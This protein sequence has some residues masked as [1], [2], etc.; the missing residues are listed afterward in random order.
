M[1]FSETNVSYVCQYARSLLPYQPCRFF[2]LLRGFVN[3][4]DRISGLVEPDGVFVLWKMRI[5]GFHES[6]RMIRLRDPILFVF[7]L[8]LITQNQVMSNVVD[9]P[10]TQRKIF[11]PDAVTLAIV[12]MLTH[13]AT[14]Y[15]TTNRT[16]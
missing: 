9:L 15:Q 3:C 7:A 10:Q 11:E 4:R 16:V 8:H 5:A 6:H 2:F 1:S 13:D 12:T 14:P